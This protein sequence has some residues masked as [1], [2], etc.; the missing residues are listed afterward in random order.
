VECF[1]HAYAGLGKKDLVVH[2][3]L[4]DYEEEYIDGEIE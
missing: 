4:V 1:Q 2:Q 3:E